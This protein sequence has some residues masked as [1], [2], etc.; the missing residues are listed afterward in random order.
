MSDGG[1]ELK[2]PPMGSTEGWASLGTG[3]SPGDTAMGTP[4]WCNLLL[5]VSFSTLAGLGM[6]WRW[7]NLAPTGL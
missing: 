5:G 4:T 2:A 3:L 6:A 1:A 7:L